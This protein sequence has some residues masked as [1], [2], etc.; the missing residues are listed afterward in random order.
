MHRVA[1]LHAVVAGCSVGPEAASFSSSSTGAE[2]QAKEQWQPAETAEGPGLLISP[3]PL[4]RE[5]SQE[6]RDEEKW[7]RGS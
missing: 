2:L 6:S 3:V 7:V 1:G 4:L 5:G